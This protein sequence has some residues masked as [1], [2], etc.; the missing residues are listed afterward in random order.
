MK[1]PERLDADLR[2]FR[3]ENELAAQSRQLFVRN[4]DLQ[5][6]TISRYEVAP[7]DAEPLAG[8]LFITELELYPHLPNPRRRGELCDEI[9]VALMELIC[10]RPEIPELIAGRTFSRVLH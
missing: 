2:S 7:E 3:S 10:D 1:T 8:D 4:P 9:T 5:G 6:F